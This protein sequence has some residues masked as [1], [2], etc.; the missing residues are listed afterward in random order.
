MKKIK[1][2]VASL[3]IGSMTLS[4]CADDYLDTTPTQGVSD[5]TVFATSENLMT[6]INGMHRN[7]YSRQDDSQGRNG[8][9]AQLIFQDALG[10]DLIFPATGN[11]WF[12]SVLRY[13]ETTNEASANVSYPWDFWYRM[14]K[15]A[16][17][18]IVNGDKATGD[19]ALKEKAIGEAYAYRAFGHFQLVQLYAGRYVNGQDNNQLGVVVRVDP[20]DNDPK[21]R[22]TVE[23]VYTQVWKDLDKAQELLTGKAKTNNSHFAL[24]NILGI[25]ARVAL[26]QQKYSEASDYAQQAR[27]GKSLMTQAEYKSGFNDYANSEW[28]WGVSVAADQSDG[29][30]NFM[31]YMSRNFN[32]SQIRQSPK[33]VNKILFNAFPETDVRRE[34]IS[35][36]GLHPDLG[37]GN[38]Y[39]KFNYTSQKFITKDKNNSLALGDVPF[40][41]IAEMYLIEAEAKYYLGNEAGSKTI[42]SELV[43]ARNTQFSS[44]TTSG[45]AY[46]SELMLNRR[47]ELWG[48]GFRFLD[49]KRTNTPLNR[50]NSGASGAVI[51]NVWEIPVGSFRWTWLIPRQELNSNP[52]C[53]QNPSSDPV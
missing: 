23:E 42:L 46:L 49:L 21:A 7:M 5:E 28:M 3:L 52:L 33:V 9:T 12:I 26:V 1:Y 14:I 51:N 43:K 13:N 38:T 22:S 29:F 36:N 35:A 2:I 45:A 32:S 48:E 39:A 15:N 8:Y 11:N 40:M 27:N 47:L 10:E 34:V 37:L 17:N 41:R 44:F 20:S 16:N 50:N 30:G 24:D 53:K 18:I 31:A 6:A 4:S 19:V 25:K